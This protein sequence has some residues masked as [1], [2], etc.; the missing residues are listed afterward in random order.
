MVVMRR[1]GGESNMVNMLRGWL[2]ALVE[3]LRR[4]LASQDVHANGFWVKGGS[5]V[6]VPAGRVHEVPRVIQEHRM[7]E[8]RTELLRLM[9]RH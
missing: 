6:Y 9:T 7:Q 8:A 5:L 4:T 2:R 3:R 1:F